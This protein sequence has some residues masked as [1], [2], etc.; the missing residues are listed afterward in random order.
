MA[1][2]G[3]KPKPEDQ[4]RNKNKHVDW[5]EVVDVPF[6]DAPRFPKYRGLSLLDGTEIPVPWPKA[7]KRWWRVVSHMPH[8]I[9]WDESDWQF[10]LDTALVA[11]AFHEGK[12]T[13][14]VEL[15]NRE[16]ILGLTLDARRDL[17]IR[18]VEAVAEQERPAIAAI[19]DYRR[20]IEG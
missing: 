20:S 13:Q 16:K 10:A 4:R 1:V 11:A 9:L 6:E 7:T 17:R 14:A 2:V 15:R 18:Y 5:I 12:M 8:C 3:R 19:E